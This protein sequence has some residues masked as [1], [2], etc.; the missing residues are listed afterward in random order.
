MVK[1]NGTELNIAGK[2]VAE[3]LLKPITIRSGSQWSE[4]AILCQRHSTRQR[5]WQTATA[6]K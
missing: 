2:T 1:V 4:M 6:W 3:Y 5:C